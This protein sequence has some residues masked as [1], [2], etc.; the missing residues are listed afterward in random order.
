[1]AETAPGQEKTW[2]ALHEAIFSV[3]D[4]PSQIHFSEIMYNPIGGGAYEFLELK[5]TGDRKV[6]LSNMTIEGIRF[7][8]PNTPP[9]PAGELIVLVRDPI[10]FAERYPE[11]N[12][13]GIYEGQLSNGGERIT[14]KDHQGQVLI[15]IEYDDE[16]G[17]PVSPDGRGDSLVPVNLDGDINNPENWRASTHLY[18]SPGADNP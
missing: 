1:L 17:W 3:V 4:Q 16:N 14:L 5:N 2:S 11:V 9:L 13:G 15:S 10:A 8:F 12:I 18:G 7:S 6:D